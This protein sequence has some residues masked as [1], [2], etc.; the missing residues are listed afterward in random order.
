LEPGFASDACT[1]EPHRGIS[2]QCG[3]SIVAILLDHD[4]A[5][6]GAFAL[7]TIEPA[8]ID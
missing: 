2:L 6:L 4:F 3:T 7:L 1:I 8:S 5:A